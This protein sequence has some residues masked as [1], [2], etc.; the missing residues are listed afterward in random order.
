M[1]RNSSDKEEWL[2]KKLFTAIIRSGD[3]DEGLRMS[4]KE[5]VASLA[6]W[7]GKS[8]DEIVTMVCREIGQAT[9]AVLKEPLAQIIESQKVQITFEFVPKKKTG[10]R[11]SP[12]KKS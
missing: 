6:Q 4:P 8:K 11:A 3:G 9:A 2:L 10:R 5:L 7:A 1:A 12:S